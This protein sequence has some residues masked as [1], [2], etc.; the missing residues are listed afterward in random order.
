MR[1]GLSVTRHSIHIKI[2]GRTYAGSYAVDRGVLTVTA[3]YGRKAAQV[4]HQ[5]SHET[6]ARQLL[7]KLVQEEKSRKGSR[8]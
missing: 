4:G 7:L 8:L 6:L 1:G 5:V 2:D 3:S